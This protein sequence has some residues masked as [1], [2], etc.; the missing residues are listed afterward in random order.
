MLTEAIAR[1]PSPIHVCLTA[2]GSE[3]GKL[4]VSNPTEPL[5]SLLTLLHTP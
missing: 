2:W 4:M 5:T 1:Y 3:L